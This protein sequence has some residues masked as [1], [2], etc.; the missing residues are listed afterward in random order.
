MSINGRHIPFPLFILG[1]LALVVLGVFLVMTIVGT[2]GPSYVEFLAAFMV[3][4]SIPVFLSNVDT[5]KL[6]YYVWILSFVIGYRGV[7]LTPHLPVY[8]VELLL[9]VLFIVFLLRYRWSHTDQYGVDYKINIPRWLWIL[10]IF[11]VFALF[12]GQIRERAFDG[13]LREMANYLALFPIFIL[14]AQI[15]RSRAAWRKSAVVFVLAGCIIAMMGL[16][17][18]IFPQVR[19]LAGDFI[20]EVPNAVAW[21]GF[22]RGLFAI[23]GAA[24]AAFVCFLAA[25]FTFYLWV[26]YQQIRNRIFILLAAILLLGGVYISGYRSLW[27]LT[28][29]LTGLFIM[30]HN[31]LVVGATY[32]MALPVLYRLLPVQ[33][34]NWLG[35]FFLLKGATANLDSSQFKRENRALLAFQNGLEHP[36]GLG[37]NGIAGTHS[38]FAQM[39]S[40]Q[41][42]IPTLIII[43]VFLFIFFHLARLLKILPKNESTWSLTLT[44]FLATIVLTGL[45]IFQGIHVLPQMSLPGWFVLALAWQWLQQHQQLIPASM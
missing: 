5:L 34:H 35:T 38:D 2:R 29:I 4:A 16:V 11:W 22:R 44:L 33:Q 10:S 3:L 28:V 40:N 32:F 7:F 26:E 8:P 6:G 13:M 39:L 20:N 14:T 17:E 31:G 30:L 1:S 41:G 42:W 25:P 36:Q 15:V 12:F 23:W 24:T 19:V 37:W 21:T 18:Y 27:V 45:M 9:W 43:G